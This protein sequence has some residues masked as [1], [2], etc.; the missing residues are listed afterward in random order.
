M[1]RSNPRLDAERVSQALAG[2]AFPA[3]KWQLIMHAEEYGADGATRAE[4]WA[5]PRGSYSDPTAVLAALAATHDM[6]TDGTPGG[7]DGGG[8]GGPAGHLS[9][10]HQLRPLRGRHTPSVAGRV[11]PLR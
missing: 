2:M 9:R 10:H 5:L 3:A 4:L 7:E 6:P 8:A 11:R 1:Y